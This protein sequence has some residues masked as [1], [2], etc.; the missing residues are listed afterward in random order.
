MNQKRVE[1][2]ISAYS[3]FNDLHT[4]CI[5]AI[6]APNVLSQPLN[7][8]LLDLIGSRLSGKTMQVLRSWAVE[9]PLKC[10]IENIKVAINIIRNEPQ[11]AK[12]TFGELL[13]VVEDIYDLNLKP[14]QINLTNKT[15]ALGLSDIRAIGVMSNRKKGQQKLGLARK[16][17]KKDI[18]INIFEEITEFENERLISM[19]NQA[20]GGAKLNIRIK[21]ANPWVMKMFFVKSMASFMGFNEHKLRK[22]GEIFK[23]VYYG[24]TKTLRIGHITNHRINDFL[25][26]AQHNE[27][28]SIWNFDPML[29]RVA[30]LGMPGVAEG[31]IY[32]PMWNKVL[33]PMRNM[34]T[35]E[36]RAGLD[37]GTS[38][39]PNGSATAMLLGRIGKDYSFIAID[40]EYYHSNAKQGYKNDDT[41]IRE[42]V[43]KLIDFVKEN[44][45]GIL[46]TETQKLRVSYDH[47]TFLLKKTL[48]TELAIRA[49]TD[50]Q[51]VKLISIHPCVKWD[52]AVR[53]NIKSYLISSGH[54]YVNKAKCVKHNEEMQG[55]MWS[56]TEMVKGYPTKEKIDDHTDDAGC[57]LVS[58]LYPRFI[59]ESAL[60]HNKN[61]RRI[62]D[63]V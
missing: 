2:I 58:E 56:E 50:Y 43:T 62:T 21:I 19:V 13:S 6:K 52:T 28:T 11:G 46:S 38:T 8:I 14:K 29:A 39:G 54:Y 47:A 42:I 44:K 5:N 48:E 60:K 7:E 17:A 26:E 25:S 24:A 10:S 53:I 37:W 51:Y 4:L 57:Y 61:L 59:S 1:K 35:K 15:L 32:A 9:F 30:D 55:L 49:Q 23:Q 41:L 27:L 12:E 16:G 31:L 18:E 36:Y 33:E 63:S 34:P 40:D 20:T 22:D 45:Q 3:Y